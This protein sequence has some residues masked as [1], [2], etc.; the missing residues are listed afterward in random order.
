M[1][2]SSSDDQRIEV[3]DSITR[4]IHLHFIIDNVIDID[5]SIGVYVFD[6]ANPAVT[7]WTSNKSLCTYFNV[8]TNRI[9]DEEDVV[10]GLL[11]FER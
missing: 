8:L 11:F 7:V 5:R 6:D 10:G 9:H 1:S 4:N 2:T 3:N